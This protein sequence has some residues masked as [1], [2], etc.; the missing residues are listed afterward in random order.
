MSQVE[1]ATE[2]LYEDISM[3]SELTDTEAN[4]LLQWGEKEIARLAERGLSDEEFD[5][6]FSNLKKLLGNINRFTGH[7]TE[8][9]AEESQAQL[10][11]MA[12][13]AQTL[14][15]S[16][17]LDSLNAN[18]AQA[19]AQGAAPDNTATIQAII[20]ALT[21]TETPPAA[22]TQPP[23]DTPPAAES[24]SPTGGLADLW[25][26]VTHFFNQDTENADDKEK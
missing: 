1:R 19:A 18:S 25:K 23:A 24:Q 20:G 5:E 8:M 15:H 2:R 22:E 21:A 13:A 12:A 4:V 26:N 14:G 16:P 7:R 6:L 10:N 17:K 3:R 9:S 11:A